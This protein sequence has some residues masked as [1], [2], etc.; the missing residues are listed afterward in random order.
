MKLNQQ[1][2]EAATYSGPAR[3]VLVNAGA[4]CGKT[5]TII[6]RAVHLIKTGTDA[7][8]ILMVT[9]TNRAASEMKTRLKS[10]VGVVAE[11]VHAGTFHAFCL[12]VMS[13]IPN[14][15][16]VSGLNIIDVDD[17]NSLMKVVRQRELKV[18]E[19]DTK[20]E[21]PKPQKLVKYLSYSRNT[22][23]SPREYIEIHSGLSDECIPIC[24]RIFERY[25]KAKDRRGYL[26]FDDLLEIFATMLEEKP[27]LRQAI[28]SVYDEVLVDEMQDTNPLQ[29]RIL[30]SFAEEGTRLFCVGD[31]AQSIY[32][33]RGA[34]FKQIYRFTELFPDSV[35][36]KLSQNYRSYQGILN[37]S[38]WLLGQSPYDYEN[39]LVASRGDT[40]CLPRVC[41]FDDS[42]KEASW[43]ADEVQER[44]EEEFSYNDIMILARTG[45]GAK[46]LEAEFIRREIPYR[47]IGG[48]A[49][50]KSA[51]VRDILSLLRVIRNKQDELAWMRFMKLWPRIGERTAEKLINAFY[52]DLE[53]DPIDIFAKQFGEDHGAVVAFKRA[54]GKANIPQ[55]CVSAAVEGLE[56]VLRDRYDKWEYRYQDL[57]LLATVAAQ[58]HSL[59]EFVDAFTLEPLSET[60]VRRRENDEA[61]TLITVHSAKGTEANICYVI[62]A[63]QGI[64]PHSRSYGDLEYEEEERRILYVAMTRARNELII[65][66]SAPGNATFFMANTPTQGEEYFLAEIPENLIQRE[67]L[68]WEPSDKTGL[69]S[70]KDIY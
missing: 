7:S 29:F 32:K 66:R 27:A 38:N 68:G 24:M 59:G 52:E 16:E 62:D 17:Q 44:H 64:Y 34:E 35:E 50:T 15:F 42:Y 67:I 20:K 41:D 33:F 6:G 37:L 14:S 1:Q 60:E 19:R 9:F 48:T 23:Q 39:D 46:P 49:L 4:G 69:S 22:C 43:I 51:H 13:K 25:K 21:I 55:V 28:A 53:T 58:Y 30:E 8:R 5:G 2:R 57:R 61:V 70:L 12:Q 31:P 40:D 11:Q 36:L 47:F 65:T 54:L 45:Y 10:E 63:K 3:N 26:D 18:V 56:P